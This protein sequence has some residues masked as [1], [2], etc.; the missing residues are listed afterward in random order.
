MAKKRKSPEEVFTPRSAYV[1]PE[2]YIGREFL[3]NRLA[4]SLRGNKYVIIHGESGNGKTWLYKKVLSDLGYDYQIVNLA[5]ANLYGSISAAIEDK[6]GNLG[7]REDVGTEMTTT[8]GFR[9]QNIGAD[10]ASKIQEAIQAKGA[11]SKLIGWMRREAGKKP[12]ALIFDN[13]EQVIENALVISQLKALIIS[14]DDEEIAREGVRLIIVGV[15]GNLKE[16]IA[17]TPGAAPIVNRLAEIPEVARIDEKD[18]KALFEK[19]LFET[20][21]YKLEGT[22]KSLFLRMLIFYTDRIAQQVHEIGLRLSQEAE[23]NDRIISD[24]VISS[25]MMHWIMDSMSSDWGVI[26]QAMNAK[27]TKVGRKDQVLYCM[28]RADRD[29]FKTSEIENIL[30]KE[31]EVG[32]VSLNIS[33]ILSGF[34]NLDNPILKRTPK[35]DAWRFV[36]PKFKIA[37]R[38]GLHKNEEGKVEKANFVKEM[39]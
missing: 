31:F 9:P 32:S 19:G 25:A 3:E 21:G 7:Y 34:A 8:A 10:R 23:R 1:N 4:D 18:V 6:L 15:P 30:K 12:C 39:V 16:M 24:T 37:I 5:N 22:D 27:E 38:V 36:S 26:E 11:F 29:E 17:K 13:F 2:M 28:S 14:A 33:Q 35:D 20:L